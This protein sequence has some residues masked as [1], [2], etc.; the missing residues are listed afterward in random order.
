MFPPAHRLVS[1]PSAPIIGVTALTANQ[2]S[3]SSLASTLGGAWSP[4]TLPNFPGG[5]TV[6]YTPTSNVLGRRACNSTETSK[7][8]QTFQSFSSQPMNVWR[9]SKL[10]V[11]QYTDMQMTA[12]NRPRSVNGQCPAGS[13]PCGT[14]S[15]A[16]PEV[17]CTKTFGVCPLTALQV[18]TAPIPGWS[19][20]PTKFS[21]TMPSPCTMPGASSCSLKPASLQ[22]SAPLQST[23]NLL[24][25]YP[26]GS[27]SFYDSYTTSSS[28]TLFYLCTQNSTSPYPMVKTQITL[29]PK[30]VSDGI[31][32]DGTGFGQSD[33][34]KASD[35]I[36]DKAASDSLSFPP[37]FQGPPFDVYRQIIHD[38]LQDVT[39]YKDNSLNFGSGFSYPYTPTA[40]YGSGNCYPPITI[41]NMLSRL[42]VCALF[43][44]L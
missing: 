24:P 14:A 13:F 34:R 32:T 40:C 37:D 18:T 12:A 35:R 1:L 4:I 10:C 39:V 38:Y 9:S 30:C 41:A 42:E 31:T 16:Q 15:A 3:C 8:A 29:N 44:F 27:Q 11:N 7:G 2:A 21:N 33:S 36:C 28:S 25:P 43:A 6:C 5:D 23:G 26:G 17:F 19:C 22:Q 20:S